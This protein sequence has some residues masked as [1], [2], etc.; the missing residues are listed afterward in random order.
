MNPALQEAIKE[1][2]AI[3]PATKVILN[4]IEIRQEGVQD[5]VYLVQ[6]RRGMVAVDENGDSHSFEPVGF[7]FSLPPSN[8]EGFQ[9]LNIAIDN[10]GLRVTNFMN[11]AMS[12]NE[13]IKVIYRPYLSDDLTAPQ[14]IPP[15]VLFLR[16]VRITAAQVVGRATFMDIVNK[17]FPAELYTRS[18]FPSLG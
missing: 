5:P 3:A 2:F 15:L 10:V 11:T 8:E 9:S 17:K 1:A 16:D 18:R 4:T 13:P 7:Q 14:M 12:Q 6:A